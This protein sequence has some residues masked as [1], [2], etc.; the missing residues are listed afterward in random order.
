MLL[1]NTHIQVGLRLYE[2]LQS[3]GTLI[4]ETKTPVKR[5]LKPS[6]TKPSSAKRSPSAEAAAAA[7]GSSS[8]GDSYHE[9]TAEVMPS[10]LDSFIVLW[11]E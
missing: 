6:P 3:G 11:Q 1:R 7:S 2:E 8:S 4:I 5:K 10:R 9:P